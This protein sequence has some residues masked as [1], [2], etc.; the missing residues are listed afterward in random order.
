MPCPAQIEQLSSEELALHARAGYED[1]FAELL[2][3]H[4]DSLRGFL[5]RRGSSS[6]DA[7]D[8][9]QAAF[10]R[11][12]ERLDQ[13]DPRY[14]FS[15]WIFTIAR[16][17]A[18]KAAAKGAPLEEAKEEDCVDPD[19]PREL[20]ERAEAKEN[21]WR[22]AGKALPPEQAEALWLMYA[23]GL[24]VAEIAGR[25]GRSKIYVRVLLHRA[26]TKLGAALRLQ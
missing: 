11:A 24:S 5:R 4:G 16:N 22:T 14:R 6:Q 18:S 7:E 21:L 2:R 10:S 23:K 20:L 12:F 19:S 26:R 9:A 17:M 1:C 3:R 13:Y 8:L 15:T 25:T